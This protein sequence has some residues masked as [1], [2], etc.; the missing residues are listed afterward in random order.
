M[1][2][3]PE[4]LPRTAQVLGGA[5]LLVSAYLAYE[6]FTSS[7]TL[8]CPETGV[9]NCAEVTSRTGAPVHYP[10]DCSTLCRVSPSPCCAS[11]ER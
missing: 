2:G 10:P 4:A 8:A 1:H 11:S 9:V 7:T 6:H 5:G 3:I